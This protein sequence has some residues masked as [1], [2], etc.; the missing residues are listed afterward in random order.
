M[1]D[2]S[3]AN[4][5]SGKINSILSQIQA[6]GGLANCDIKAMFTDGEITLQGSFETL[7]QQQNVFDNLQQIE[8][9]SRIINNTQVINPT[10]NQSPT[11]QNNQW[12]IVRAETGFALWFLGLIFWFVNRLTLG[13]AVPF[14]TVM[15]YQQWASNVRIDGRRVRFV[16]TAGSL[17]GVWISTLILSIITFGLYWIFIG[18]A[19]VARWIDSNLA[20][21]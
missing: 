6:S 10:I 13:L 1:A 2:D 21:A 7:A 5:I 11:N 15:Y 14:T 20:W 3:D 17:M 19:N 4:N 18:K 12:K 8:G 16:G 9:V